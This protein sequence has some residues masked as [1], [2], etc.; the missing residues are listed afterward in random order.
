M[1]VCTK[2]A[3]LIALVT[4]STA[5][6]ASVEISNQP[7]HHMNCSGGVC[8]STAKKAVLN[9]NDVVGML[10][11]GDLTVKDGNGAR[12]ISVVN[13]LSWAGSSK[14][15]LQASDAVV[16]NALVQVEGT[17]AL[18]I[19]GDAK[20][21]PLECSGD[22]KIQFW[23]L[24][25][26]FTIN[27]V[28]FKLVSDIHSLASG[29]ASNPH[30]SFA[31]SKN[32]DASVD[33]TYSGSPIRTDFG[34]KFEGACN[35]IYNLKIIDPKDE[36]YLKDALF[37][38]TGKAAVLSNIV[39]IHEFVQGGMDGF[40]GGLVAN[41]FGTI[42]RPKIAGTV[43]GPELA[44]FIGGIAGANYGTIIDGS[45]RGVVKASEYTGGIAGINYGSGKI[46]GAHVSGT[47]EMINPGNGFGLQDGLGGLV[48][49]NAGIVTDSSS[50]SVVQ[51]ALPNTFI[52]GLVG[53]N[54]G[55]VSK[56]S[57]TG[58]VRLK[59]AHGTAGGVVGTNFGGVLSATASGTVTSSAS[60]ETGG[61]VGENFGTIEKSSASGAVNGG[62]GGST[63]GLVG[64][65]G[66]IYPGVIIDSHASGAVTA[67]QAVIGG[68]AG[69]MWGIVQ[70]CSATGTVT[71]GDDHS[72]VGG[73]IGY[74]TSSESTT[75]ITQS[76]SSGA[77]SAGDNTTVGGLVGY[78][79]GDNNLTITDSYTL[80][81]ISVGANVTVGGFYGL[82]DTNTLRTYSAGSLTSGTGGTVGG[83]AGVLLTGYSTQANDYWDTTTSGLTHGVG[84]GDV[85][86]ITGVTD[87]QLKSGLPEGF[88][89]KVWAQSATI[90]NGYP[91]LIANPPPQ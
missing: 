21:W 12:G 7:T 78:D 73:L 5:A 6:S 67:S 47:V 33:G 91:Y 31:L 44:P 83:F 27:N 61:L 1:R 35:A 79:A 81:N 89:A 34:G 36:A 3:L 75:T 14:L 43:T 72:Y 52:G 74:A 29:I 68:L 56:S 84:G 17:S 51:S 42:V 45:F 55:V 18:T 57:A 88:D 50:E 69:A 66:E 60:S 54:S 13:N 24:N 53:V 65:D 26:V 85:D 4:C 71:A 23:D 80:S 10:S 15:T 41:N 70:N 46:I 16:V 48:G 37:A 39:L 11:S 64:D 90:N 9:V 87:S 20:N 58:N 32:Y 76:Y 63:G 49:L 59:P 25:S 28:V 22:G 86:G 82:S 77:I 2:L 30:G 62:H 38:K 8:S 19:E 40:L